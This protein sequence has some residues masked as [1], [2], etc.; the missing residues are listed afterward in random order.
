[1]AELVELLSLGGPVLWVLVFLS[2]FSLTIIFWKIVRLLPVTGGRRRRSEAIGLWA[3]GQRDEAA[4]RARS[5]A[6]PADQLLAEAMDWA[7]H[8]R[9]AP[10]IEAEMTR[11]G[12]ELLSSLGSGIRLLELIAMVAPLIGLLGTVTGMIRAFRDLAMAEGSANASILA[13]GIWEALITTA[14]GL[15][16]A[17]PAAV[18]AGLLS[19]RVERAG[20]AVE[21]AVGAFLSL[22]A[23]E[24]VTQA[25]EAPAQ[26]NY[27]QVG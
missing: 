10:A 12:N 2:V 4:S 25:P 23:E 19:A 13:G 21:S 18:A 7:S 20:I 3:E 8:G 14:A 15:I 16:V 24:G 11:R 17:I 1:M 9:A 27:G 22:Y 26:Y 5:G 6:A